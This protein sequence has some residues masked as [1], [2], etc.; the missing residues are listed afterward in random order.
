M[1]DPHR[2]EIAR[3]HRV[4]H[5]LGQ[6]AVGVGERPPSIVTLLIRFRRM[7]KSVMPPTA[8]TPGSRAEPLPRVE[9]EPRD[10]GRSMRDD[11]QVLRR[12]SRDPPPAR[13]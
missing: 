6:A 3:R 1:I 4:H 2:A 13:G 10:A 8:T 9:K 12:D 5:Q 7:K 11:Q